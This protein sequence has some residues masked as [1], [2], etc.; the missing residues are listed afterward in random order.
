MIKKTKVKF[1]DGTIKTQI[2]V[3]EGVRIGNTVSHRHIR[4][5]GYLEDNENQEAFLKMVKDFD[6]KY[7]NSKKIQL[8][9]NASESWLDDDDDRVYNFGYKFIEAIYNELDLKSFFSTIDFK[10]QYDLNEVFKFL[11]IHRILNPDSKRA[12]YQ[13]RENLFGFNPRFELHDIYRALSFFYQNSEQLQVH[14]NERVKSIIGR[15]TDKSFYDTTNY[16][17]EIDFEDEDCYVELDKKITDKKII[18]DQKIIERNIDGVI[19]Q[20]EP[21]SGFKKCGVSKRNQVTPIVQLSLMIDENKLPICME[22]FPGNT[23]DSKTLQPTIAKVKRNYGLKRLLVVADKG[24]NSSAN[25]DC[26]VNNGD[27]FL[28]SQTL[29]GKKGNRYHDK[30]FNESLY[31][32]IDEDNKYQT[33]IEEYEGLDKFGNKVIRNR[34]VL[35]Y[36]SGE[37]DRR[38]KKKRE[39]KI[40]KAKNLIRLGFATTS[41]SST[42]YIESIASI[43]TTGEIADNLQLRID[44]EKIENESRF[45]G[46]FCIITS[47]L[48]YDYKMIKTTYGGLWTIEDTFKIST[49][50]IYAR[51]IYLTTEN[52][53]RGHFITCF[54]ALLIIRML[55][56]KLNFELSA[57]RIIRALNLCSCIKMTKELIKLV[58]NES[59]TDFETKTSLKGIEY[60]TMKTAVQEETIKDIRLIFSSFNLEEYGKYLRIDKFETKLSQITYTK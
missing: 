34:K 13:R 14:L 25:I 27:G 3:V 4:G 46:Y 37:D 30:L 9:L 5:F 43:S 22:M 40:N 8:E 53:I 11:V 59:F 51:P 60:V 20:F 54:T 48:D 23:A 29:R 58:K 10:G 42:K 21:I 28:F 39:S 35:L 19:R 56:L 17:F 12:T 50:D 2:R 49:T 15:D 24:I 1:K 52:H 36:Y 47:E 31:T 41:H 18:K 32:V 45:D 16:H 7:Q 55:Q 33:F 44:Q 38:T 26:I 6:D 57:E